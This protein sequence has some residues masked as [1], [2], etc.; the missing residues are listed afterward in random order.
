MVDGA[1]LAIRP[2]SQLLI[3]SYRFSNNPQKAK[4]DASIVQL[5]RGGL[6]AVTGL[7][8]KQNPI[9]AQYRTTTATIGVRG[10]DFELT[11][12]EEDTREATAGTYSRTFTGATYLEN[13]DGNRV[14]VA[15]GR[16]AY[17]PQDTINLA[18][19]FG[20]LR[21]V[22]DVFFRGSFDNVLSGLQQEAVNRLQN[23]ISRKL[24]SQLQQIL[25]GIGDFFKR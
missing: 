3:N 20:L 15:A 23:E 1:L 18:R 4:E 16:S 13:R 19:Q 7:I 5:L 11:V 12:L 24:P 6:R 14:E 17:S 8:G 2:N 10:T 9:G 22:P 25:P 21:N